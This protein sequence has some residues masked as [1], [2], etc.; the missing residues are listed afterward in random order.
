MVTKESFENEMREALRAGDD[1]KKRTLRMILTAIKLAEV[2][3]REPL[4]EAGLMRLL[5]KEAKARRE[6]IADA[7]RAG[8]SDL[9]MSA[10]AELEL[11]E[12]YLP[13]ALKPEE[14]EALVRQAIQDTG[15]AE[16]KDMGNVMK[17]LIP[18]IQGRAEGKEVSDLVRKLLTPA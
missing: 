8:R 1:L 15:A 5:Q 9:T 18:Q 16:P 12:T 2:E 14:L 4:D 6:T 17:A 3:R 10:Q 13:E 7:E 11:L